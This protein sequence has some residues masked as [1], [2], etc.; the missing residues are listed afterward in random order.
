MARQK[1]REDLQKEMKGDH[2][3][4]IFHKYKYRLQIGYQKN[5]NAASGED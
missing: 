3:R 2:D 4:P 5:P 1:I